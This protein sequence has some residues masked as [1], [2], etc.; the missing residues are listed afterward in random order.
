MQRAGVGDDA[1]VG[2]D[3]DAVQ[4]VPV[5]LEFLERHRFVDAAPLEEAIQLRARIEA[6]ELPQLGPRQPAGAVLLDRERFQR[7]ARDVIAASPTS[8]VGVG[9][10]LFWV[11]WRFDRP[12][13][14]AFL[15]RTAAADS[16]PAETAM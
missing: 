9:A 6:E 10:N 11:I 1:H 4:I 5:A 12:S 14:G 13:T 7:P 16:K 2:S 3:A 15:V 8:A